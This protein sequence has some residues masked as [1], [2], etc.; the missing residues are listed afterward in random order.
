MSKKYLSHVENLI[1]YMQL[2]CFLTSK[3]RECLFTGF[4]LILS[5]STYI[6]ELNLNCC[7]LTPLEYLRFQRKQLQENSFWLVF[8]NI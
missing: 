6:L 1:D 4:I 3:M 2:Y 7:F 8:S 5:I